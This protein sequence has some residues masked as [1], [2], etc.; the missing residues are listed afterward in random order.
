MLR[1]M[2]ASYK[3]DALPLQ[4]TCVIIIQNHNGR[5]Q[6]SA[7][8]TKAST[9]SHT[10]AY[11]ASHVSLHQ[12]IAFIRISADTDL[13]PCA[14]VRHRET[15]LAYG[16][17]VSAKLIAKLRSLART[18]RIVGRLTKNA[19]ARRSARETSRPRRYRYAVD[20]V[21]ALHTHNTRVSYAI[22]AP[23]Y[24][25]NNHYNG[26]THVWALACRP[27]KRTFAYARTLIASALYDA[28]ASD[29]AY[30]LDNCSL[31]SSSF[32]CI[33]AVV[34]GLSCALYEEEMFFCSWFVPK[35]VFV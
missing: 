17:C 33:C 22:I 5:A 11:V 18:T 16:I 27:R 31:W 15:R 25:T 4:Q 10:K 14:R 19:Y 30:L 6:A 28:H 26:W 2:S 34:L 24:R 9:T 23:H 12:S 8:S 20:M 29:C 13:R 1:G 35:D 7:F 32:V 3:K 21:H